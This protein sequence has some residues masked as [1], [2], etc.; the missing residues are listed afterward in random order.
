MSDGS[1]Q[2]YSSNVYAVSLN[3]LLGKQLALTGSQPVYGDIFSQIQFSFPGG[4]PKGYDPTL[5]DWFTSINVYQTAQVFINNQAVATMIPINYATNWLTFTTYD[6]DSKLVSY[7]YRVLLSGSAPSTVPYQGQ[8][9]D[10]RSEIAALAGQSFNLKVVVTQDW[11]VYKICQSARSIPGPCQT[12]A[13]KSEGTIQSVDFT[14]NMASQTAAFSVTLQP[15]QTFAGTVTTNAQRQPIIEITHVIVSTSWTTSCGPGCTAVGGASGTTELTTVTITNASLPS[16]NGLLSG[17]LSQICNSNPVLS[18]LC[19][20][21]FGIPN[22]ILLVVGL[23]ILYL[24]L[25]RGSTQTVIAQG[26]D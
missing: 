9:L 4:L 2:E 26:K 21:T 5:G 24:L 16:F 8:G 23:V 7:Q 17:L 14:L 18:W 10:L 25:R 1:T 12:V 19:E 22:W 15:T 20:S 11:S 3:W 13:Q 6:G